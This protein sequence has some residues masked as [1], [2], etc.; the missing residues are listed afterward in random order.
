[1]HVDF[2]ESGGEKRFVPYADLS[3]GV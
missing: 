3:C 1:V 2:S